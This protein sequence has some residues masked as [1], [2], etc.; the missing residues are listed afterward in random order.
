MSD[1]VV[2][3]SYA[4]G[5][6]FYIDPMKLLPLDRFLPQPKGVGVRGAGRGGLPAL[7]AVVAASCLRQSHRDRSTVY[8][9]IWKA[10]WLAA[11][12]DD[13]VKGSGCSGSSQGVAEAEGEAAEVE[14][15][16]AEV[17]AAA[18][19]GAVAAGVSA[20]VVVA[21]GAE[22]SEVAVEVEGDAFRQLYI[23]IR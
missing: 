6:K 10:C 9:V 13:V 16:R 3:T 20:A 4:S 8:D 12:E 17:A 7:A 19:V 1:G 5:D 2:A 22:V 18:L 15:R 14:A 23:F 21:E 11:W